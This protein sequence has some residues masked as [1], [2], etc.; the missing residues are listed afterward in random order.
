MNWPLREW[1]LPQYS[2]TA[3]EQPDWQLGVVAAS[4]CEWTNGRCT[5]E[6]AL[7]VALVPRTATGRVL[8]I[9]I[10]VDWVRSCRL[11]KTVCGHEG[12]F[13]TLFKIVDNP[14]HSTALASFALERLITEATSVNE[15]GACRLDRACLSRKIPAEWLKA[16]ATELVLCRQTD[17]SSCNRYPKTLRAT[18]TGSDTPRFGSI[19]VSPSGMTA[20]YDV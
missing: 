8:S 5:L 19:H 7:E 14:E 20:W 10:S 4:P 15:H 13:N 17:L 12:T 1:P 6:A 3:W 9:D 18:A 2:T 11:H 16:R